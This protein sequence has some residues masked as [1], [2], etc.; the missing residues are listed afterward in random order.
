MKGRGE[1]LRTKMMTGYVIQLV[2]KH[3]NS[4]HTKVGMFVCSPSV[5]HYG[6]TDKL[7]E[8]KVF[9]TR[10]QADRECCE[11]E[12]VVPVADAFTTGSV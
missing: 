4:R 9:A 6:W 12:R 10:E 2:T 7:Q 3:D 1:D 5:R 8:A 11:N